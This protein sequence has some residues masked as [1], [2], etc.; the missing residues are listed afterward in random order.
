MAKGNGVCCYLEEIIAINL[1]TSSDN[2]ILDSASTSQISNSEEIDYSS[3]EQIINLSS[4]SSGYS[5]GVP[6]EGP[7]VASV[8]EE[9]P[10]LK[11][12]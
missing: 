12:C 7:S 11:D 1:D 10:S 5:K 4:N 2:S 8:P 9:G 3:P 6:K